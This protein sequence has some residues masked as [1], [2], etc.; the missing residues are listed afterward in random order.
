MRIPPTHR[1][2][3]PVPGEA[4]PASRQ[5]ITVRNFVITA[6]CLAGAAAVHLRTDD[7]ILA[8]TTLPVLHGFLSHWIAD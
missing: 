1:P 8:T 6:V 3:E 4:R 7:A 2:P 5:V